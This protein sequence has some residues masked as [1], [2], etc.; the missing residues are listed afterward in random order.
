M[1]VRY[2][3]MYKN[4]MV[5]LVVGSL[6]GYER[7]DH[8]RRLVSIFHNDRY[9][10]TCVDH[11]KTLHNLYKYLFICIPFSFNQLGSYINKQKL[12]RFDKKKMQCLGK[13]R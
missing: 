2:E 11:K 9:L 5:P 1:N 3:D 7:R 12:I 6:Y 4:N 10:L 8:C 13:N